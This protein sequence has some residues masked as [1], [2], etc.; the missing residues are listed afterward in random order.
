GGSDGGFAEP[1]VLRGD[2]R[3]RDGR[4]DGGVGAVWGGA[5]DCGAVGCGGRGPADAR[6]AFK[7]RGDVADKRDRSSAMSL[8]TGVMAAQAAKGLMEGAR[9]LVQSL[10]KPKAEKAAFAE[11]LRERLD[12]ARE[13]GRSE[14]QALRGERLTDRAFKVGDADG[15]GFLDQTES[16]LDAALFTKLDT[17]GDGRLSRDEV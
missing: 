7:E 3:R 10:R 15:N 17:D 16:G 2:V 11:L 5:A 14:R 9:G 6:G 8:I 13:T 1:A 4:G 12:A